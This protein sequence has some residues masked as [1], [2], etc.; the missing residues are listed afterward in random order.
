MTAQS[1]S[2][3]LVFVISVLSS[4]LA[5]CGIQVYLILKE[6][7]ESIKKLNKM[8]D[9]MGMISSSVAKP[10]SGFSEFIMGL[11]TGLEA[12]KGLAG[13]LKNFGS[14]KSAKSEEEKKISEPEFPEL[15]EGQQKPKP[16]LFFKKQGKKL[17]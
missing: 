3:L 12:F 11:K 16:R 1:V 13:L 17:S 7:R 9:D 4:V 14:G 8:L 5:I 10:I 15:T 6:F 2:I